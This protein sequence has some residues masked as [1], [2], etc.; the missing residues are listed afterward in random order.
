M[1][2]A[3]S[4]DHFVFFFF[5]VPVSNYLAT[6][7]NTFFRKCEILAAKESAEIYLFQVAILK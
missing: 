3:I 5:F 1:A 4:W 2:Q 7:H 6:Y